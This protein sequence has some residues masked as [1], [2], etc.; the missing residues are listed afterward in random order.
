MA[1]ALTYR[2]GYGQ[3]S[4][5]DGVQ[6]ASGAVNGI[7]GTAAWPCSREAALLPGR[8]FLDVEGGG[9]F[10]EHTLGRH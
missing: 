7:R 10:N 2:Q 6:N 1:Y 5:F 3:P 9:N 8:F 4:F